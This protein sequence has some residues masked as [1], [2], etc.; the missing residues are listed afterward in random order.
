[1]PTR[2]IYIKKKHLPLFAQA[3]NVA[4]EIDTSVSY[5]VALALKYYLHAVGWRI[6]TL[7]GADLQCTQALIHFSL[8]EKSDGPQT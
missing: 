2:Q 8:K 6:E 5:I 7:Q 4:R 1:M 3:E